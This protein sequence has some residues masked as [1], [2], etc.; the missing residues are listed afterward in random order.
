MKAL[1][2]LALTPFLAAQTPA[3]KTAVEADQ[4]AKSVQA[5]KDQLDKMMPAKANFKEWAA[6]DKQIAATRAKGGPLDQPTINIMV[7]KQQLEMPLRNDPEF[8][9]WERS[10]QDVEHAKNKAKAMH[11]AEAQAAQDKVRK[12]KFAKAQADAAKKATQPK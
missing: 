11:D 7:Q 9:E 4:Q 5:R 3:P 2:I 8:L 6:L 1:L 10:P 12:E